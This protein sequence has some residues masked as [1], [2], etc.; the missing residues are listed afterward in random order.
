MRRRALLTAVLSFSGSSTPIFF[1]PLATMAFNFLE[2]ITAPTPPRPAA[3][4]LSVIIAARLI[5]FSPAG[6]MQA[7]CAFS[8]VALISSSV[9]TSVSFPQTLEA[10]RI[11]T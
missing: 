7:T 3:L 1:V 4:C 5:I 2:P 9:V 8:S 10:S 11:S 6:P